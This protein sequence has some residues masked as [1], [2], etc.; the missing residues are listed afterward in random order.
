LSSIQG[1]FRKFNEVLEKH[2]KQEE[3]YKQEERY[4]QVSYG[5][6]KASAFFQSIG[7]HGLG[8]SRNANSAVDHNANTSGLVPSKSLAVYRKRPAESMSGSENNDHDQ[9]IRHP[10][11]R[12]QQNLDQQN[13][14]Q[15]PIR[16]THDGSTSNPMDLR[17]VLG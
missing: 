7:Q 3:D 1:F 14:S 9:E 12:H 13:R 5:I 16:E 17:H 6:G 10:Q 4:K 2:H 15:E 11:I 8:A